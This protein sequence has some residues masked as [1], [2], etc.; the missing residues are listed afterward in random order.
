MPILVSASTPSTRLISGLSEAF[1]SSTLAWVMPSFFGVEQRVI[2][3]LDDVEPLVVALAHR[4]AERLLGDD[5]RQHDVVVRRGQRQADR[6]EA[7]L[8]GGV[9]VAAAGVVGGVDLLEL[10]E[11]DRIVLHLVGLEVVGE[12]ELGRGAALHA[13]RGAGEL[14]RGVHAG[15]LLGVDHEALAVIVGDAGEVQA[16]RGVAVQRPGRVARQNVD[17]ARLQSREAILGAERR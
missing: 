17:F 8:V 2:G 15:Q 7:G 4:R 13:D 14:Q 12:V 11:D 10:L 1:I 5:L 9:D 3:P 6:I 16:E